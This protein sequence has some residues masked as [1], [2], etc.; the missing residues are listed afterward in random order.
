LEDQEIPV[1]ACPIADRPA[2]LIAPNPEQ[3]VYAQSVQARAACG[4][5]H[6]SMVSQSSAVLTCPN[7]NE[8]I[9]FTLLDPMEML[10]V[11][12]T[13]YHTGFNSPITEFALI[14][15]AQRH[16]R[17]SS[18]GT[19]VIVG[20]H[21]AITAGH[22]I[23]GYFRE[24]GDEQI[25]AG[26]EG[27]FSLQAVQFIDNG[28]EAKLWNVRQLVVAGHTDIAF[29]LLH[30]HTTDQLSYS[31][32]GP[33]LQ[34][35]PPAVGTTVT[36]PLAITRRKWLLIPKRALRSGQT[37]FHRAVLCRRYTTSAATLP[38]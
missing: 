16:D 25:V 30:P 13:F 31:W 6:P 38:C 10:P 32:R 1:Q 27:P 5:C 4:C 17:L 12:P 14:L 18:L 19:A 33:K 28:A 36:A 29:L 22:V 15:L 20:N 9:R 3:R 34:L 21:L 7:I 23:Q 11:L 8:P 2:G 26:K 24:F 35:L 37:L